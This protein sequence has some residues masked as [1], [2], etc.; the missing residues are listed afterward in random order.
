MIEGVK[1]VGV[2][3][4][5]VMGAG[6]SLNLENREHLRRNRRLLRQSGE[7]LRS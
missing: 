5:G 6:G 7:F 2:V 1:T 4:A 3:G